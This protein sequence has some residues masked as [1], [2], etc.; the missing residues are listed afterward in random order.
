VTVKGKSHVGGD[1]TCLLFKHF[2]AS[3]I[4]PTFKIVNFH[5]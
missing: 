3:R 5:I 2:Q 4:I 1:A